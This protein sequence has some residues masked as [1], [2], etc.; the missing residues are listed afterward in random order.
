MVVSINRLLE[1]SGAGLNDIGRVLQALAQ[2]DLTQRMT[3]QYCGTLASLRDN[4]DLTVTR[5]QEMVGAIK[6][7]AA[8]IEGAAT[9][10]SDGSRELSAQAGAQATR[11]GE[12]SVAMQAL[13]HTVRENADEARKS[14]RFAS[15]A[16]DVAGRGGAVMT[17]AVTTM[18]AI[19]EASQKIAEFIG[20]VH[21]I[22]FQTNL[23]ALNAAVEAARAGE[24]G[25]AFAV[26]A[27]EVRSLAGRSAGAARE[28]KLLIDQSAA[29]IANGLTLVSEAGETMHEVATAIQ[30][31][32]QS[33]ARISTAC[34]TQS[35]EIDKVGR[36]IAEVDTATR[37]NTQLVEASA[38]SAKCLRK[39][40]ASLV[41]TVDVFKFDSA[42]QLVRECAADSTERW[43][44]VGVG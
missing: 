4:S 17:Q 14:A 34:Q 24:E 3:G 41:G 11:L 33:I 21:E 31:A 36:T 27:A 1:T 26:V 40:A 37:R 22:A 16:A 43:A 35:A 12:V 8:T 13:S 23:L 19:S 39:Q 6:G 7:T 18:D 38:F 9:E 42:A 30:Q 20:V 15:D 29:R 25:R 10:L 44:T 28:I 5:L 32:T 2:G